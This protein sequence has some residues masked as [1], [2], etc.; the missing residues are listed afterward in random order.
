[1]MENVNQ[2][3]IGLL[4]KK[5]EDRWRSLLKTSEK[6]G[7]APPNKEALWNKLLRRFSEG[8]RCAYCDCFLMV[9]DSRR[10][11]PQVFSIEHKISLHAGGDNSIEN[12]EIV[13]HRCNVVKGTMGYDTFLELIRLLPQPLLDRMFEEIWAGRLADK[14][15]R[16]EVVRHG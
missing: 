10:F 6:H 1:M 12:L 8:F 15:D 9:K 14:I 4:K 11:Y 7:V 5:F 13:C 2:K 16:E 3:K